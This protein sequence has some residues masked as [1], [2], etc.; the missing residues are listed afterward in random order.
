MSREDAI[1]YL[2]SIDARVHYIE[3]CDSGPYRGCQRH[4]YHRDK[5]INE[6]EIKNILKIIKEFEMPFVPI[7]MG[8]YADHIAFGVYDSS[9]KGVIA[10][11][12]EQCL[13]FS[14]KQLPDG[15]NFDKLSEIFLMERNKE[16]LKFFGLNDIHSIEKME[17]RSNY[18]Y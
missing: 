17:R 11:S 14:E 15:Y 4:A 9:N 7:D 13:V 5:K 10:D 12:G 8:G 3:T 16:L 18:T 1:G 2:S 6:N